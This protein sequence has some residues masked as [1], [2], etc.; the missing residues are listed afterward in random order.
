VPDP[1]SLILSLCSIDFGYSINS[2]L[3][4]K[5]DAQD[6]F[7]GCDNGGNKYKVL[8]LIV[9]FL[10]Y[11]G[12]LSAIGVLY[13]QWPQACAFN[14]GAITTTLLFNLLNTGLSIS[15]VAD[16]GSIL[17]SGLVF[18]YTT[19]LCYSALNSF[20]VGNC[21]P[22]LSEQGDHVGWLIASICV[23]AISVGYIAYRVGA[24]EVG[25][26]ALNGGPSKAAAM[27]LGSHSTDGNLAGG[28][29]LGGGGKQT[30]H[31]EVAVTVQEQGARAADSAGD[32]LEGRSYLT[33]HLKMA[34]I[35]VWISM[36]LTDWGVPASIQ[37]DQRYSV[38]SASA[39]LQLASCWICCVLYF[40]TLIAVKACRNRDFG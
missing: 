8:I 24:K 3:L 39:W 14:A 36:L 16:H 10:I 34:L 35:S 2:R 29:E 4:E 22:T 6:R 15:S 31:D 17:C 25:A 27:D 12:C 37:G 1:P 30:A 11:V 26:N 28:V 18:A 13:A 19:Y 9:S 40:W 21:N 20:P 5:D 23:A 32:A 7:F 38:G 33:Y